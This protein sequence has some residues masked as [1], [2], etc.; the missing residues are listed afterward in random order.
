MPDKKHENNQDKISK[1]PKLNFIW[2]IY[3]CAVALL[4]FLIFSLLPKNFKIEN[5]FSNTQKTDT[6]SANQQIT[7]QSNTIIPAIKPEPSKSDLK[8][9]QYFSGK[10]DN[11]NVSMVLNIADSAVTGFYSYDHFNV[12]INLKG[13]IEKTQE[14][15]SVIKLDELID[16]QKN[17]SLELNLERQDPTSSDVSLIGKWVKINPEKTLDVLLYTSFVENSYLSNATPNDIKISPKT[18]NE[19]QKLYT[20]VYTYPEISGLKDVKIQNT[21]NKSLAQFSNTA[22]T[23]TDFEDSLKGDTRNI[24]GPNFTGYS[25]EIDY[26]INYNQ[27]SLLS[28]EFSGYNYSG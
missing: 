1:K 16:G 18:N 21:I 2:V 14:T 8:S 13:T 28:V 26:H 25:D 22:K 19:N 3:M 6:Q 5:F 15:S 7:Q 17:A 20:I 24:E 10:I 27:N 11:Q 12:S 23:K 9:K 4:G